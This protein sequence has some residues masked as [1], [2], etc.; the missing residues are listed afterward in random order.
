MELGEFGGI[1]Q[2]WEGEEDERGGNATLISYS[3]LQSIPWSMATGERMDGRKDLKT[4]SNCG[5]VK[6]ERRRR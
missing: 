2:K 6:E 5:E 4:L 3:K 1:T